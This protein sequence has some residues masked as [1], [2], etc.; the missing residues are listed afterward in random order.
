M[1]EESVKG[2]VS[3]I[4]FQ[5]AGCILCQSLLVRECLLWKIQRAPCKPVPV[6]LD[7]RNDVHVSLSS[8]SW[9]S[10]QVH[11]TVVVWVM[12]WFLSF[13]YRFW[14]GC[15]AFS[16]LVGTGK[17]ALSMILYLGATTHGF[18]ITEEASLA[19]SNLEVIHPSA[20]TWRWVVCQ[21]LKSWA[22]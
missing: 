9:V 22:S 16:L 6:P 4:S 17:R 21:P 8:F 19:S 1:W 5:K 7:V 3:K 11:H 12:N 13:I 2:K 20:K 10:C 18:C 15:A 14:R